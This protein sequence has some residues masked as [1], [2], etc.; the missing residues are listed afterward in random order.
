MQALL[1]YLPGLEGGSFTILILHNVS[2]TISS[3]VRCPLLLGTTPSMLDSRD[4]K[5]T[6]DFHIWFI[7][8]ML[9]K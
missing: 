1:R 8:E 2:V 4:K 5:K 3:K 9:A 6:I 7:I